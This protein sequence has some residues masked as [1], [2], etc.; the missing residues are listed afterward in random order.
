MKKCRLRCLA[1]SLD[2]L[3]GYPNDP[4]TFRGT[5]PPTL[6]VHTTN[7]LNSLSG[8]IEEVQISSV[9]ISVDSLE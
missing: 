1:S 4:P 3:C 7:A 5:L 9:V 2:L 8:P 6:R